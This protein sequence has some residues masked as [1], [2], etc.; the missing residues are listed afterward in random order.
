MSFWGLEIP[1]EF[2]YKKLNDFTIFNSTKFPRLWL[3]EKREPK[4]YDQGFSHSFS[5]VLPSPSFL[6]LLISHLEPAETKRRTYTAE[7][8]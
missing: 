7:T 5:F 6:P 4:M 1:T 3:A 8:Y 2:S